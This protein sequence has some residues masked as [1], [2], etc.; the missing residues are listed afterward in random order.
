MS[1]ALL[2]S[3]GF[4]VAIGLLSS[5]SMPAAAQGAVEAQISAAQASGNVA[6]LQAILAANPGAAQQV[7]TA[8]V[9]VA[10]AA[11]SSGN[12]LLAADA[13]SAAG[14]VAQSIAGANPAFAQQIATQVLAVV[15]N[16]VVQNSSN[17]AVLDAAAAAAG[18]VVAVATA[19]GNNTLANQARSVQAATEEKE[20][21][22]REAAGQNRD[23]SGSQS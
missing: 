2:Q 22:Q 13:A 23:P 1:K 15:Q 9:A 16:S 14:Q 4:A 17:P 10:N 21:V 11:V 12:G 8:L 6:A 3:I 5:I 7:A 20:Q 19:T 18:T